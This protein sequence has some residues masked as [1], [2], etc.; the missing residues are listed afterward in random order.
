MSVVSLKEEAKDETRIKDLLRIWE[1]WRDPRRKETLEQLG[2]GETFL[3]KCLDDMPGTY[4]PACRG[5][6]QECPLCDGSGRIDLD[7][8]TGLMNPAFIRATN[9][10]MADDISARID[11]LVC[12]MRSRDKTKGYYFVIMQEYTRDG[13]ERIKA[14][15]M[16]LKVPAYRTKLCRAH[17]WIEERLF[18][19]Q[20]KLSRVG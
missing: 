19:P 18:G 5:K 14:E 12:Q 4:C 13:D 8:E 2:Y 16:L 6:N 7:P 20:V 10:A 11:R 9:K 15:R 1:V 3:K 17:A